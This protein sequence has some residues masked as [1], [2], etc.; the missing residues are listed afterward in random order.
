MCGI[1]ITGAG[2]SGLPQE[3]LNQEIR[4]ALVRKLRSRF[5][6]LGLDHYARMPGGCQVDASAP[7]H[8]DTCRR[9]PR[10]PGAPGSYDV[11]E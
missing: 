1:L 5:R 4:E 6:D 8:S 3:M 9:P 10:R 11:D 7:A 2:Q